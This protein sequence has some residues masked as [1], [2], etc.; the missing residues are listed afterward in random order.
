MQIHLKQPI[1]TNVV[2]T[3]SEERDPWWEPNR[4]FQFL[5]FYLLFV[6]YQ[7]NNLSIQT[8]SH[9]DN[10]DPSFFKLKE[11]QIILDSSFRNNLKYKS[12]KEKSFKKKF[13]FE[14]EAGRIKSILYISHIILYKFVEYLFFYIRFEI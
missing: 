13:I 12:A 1:R 10:S 2:M 6:F 8:A 14:I 3:S 4:L 5:V 9:V 11:S 7:I